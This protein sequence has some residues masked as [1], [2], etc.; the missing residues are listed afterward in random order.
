[1]EDDSSLLVSRFDIKRIRDGQSERI[2]DTVAT[3]EPL[4]IRVSYWFKDVTH[5]QSLAL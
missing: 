1:M 2:V 5:T 3:E 4:D